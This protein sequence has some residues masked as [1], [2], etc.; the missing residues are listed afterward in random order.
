MSVPSKADI[1]G[2]N[3]HKKFCE[4]PEGTESFKLRDSTSHN[5]C[6][7]EW[8]KMKTYYHQKR[9]PQQCN[10]E[11]AQRSSTMSEQHKVFRVLGAQWPHQCAGLDHV[12][13]K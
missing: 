12:S 7:L 13:L 3:H 6:D 9:D 1:F 4:N 11:K 2:S 8:D 5:L 10:M